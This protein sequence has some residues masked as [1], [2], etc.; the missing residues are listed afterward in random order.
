MTNIWDT[1]EGTARAEVRR[2]MAERRAARDDARAQLALLS[3][4]LPALG[5]PV[6]RYLASLNAEARAQRELAAVYRRALVE[7]SEATR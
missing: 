5:K 7:R 2:A 3:L 1:E 4:R 6:L